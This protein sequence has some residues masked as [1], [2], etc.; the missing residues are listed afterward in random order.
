MG[1]LRA[2]GGLLVQTPPWGV[3]RH[4]EPL[5]FIV[6]GWE[7]CGPHFKGWAKRGARPIWWTRVGLFHPAPGVNDGHV[8]AADMTQGLGQGLAESYL[9]FARRGLAYVFHP[10]L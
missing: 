4:A 8:Q 3:H 6:G 7:G 10:I 5:A 1:R 9:S 2:A